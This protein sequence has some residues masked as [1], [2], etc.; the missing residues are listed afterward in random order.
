MNSTIAVNQTIAMYGE[1]LTINSSIA[2]LYNAVP[3]VM[4]TTWPWF[5]GCCAACTAAPIVGMYIGKNRH[6][7]INFIKKLIQ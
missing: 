7:A 3:D 6:K 1:H 5:I 2:Q 4:I